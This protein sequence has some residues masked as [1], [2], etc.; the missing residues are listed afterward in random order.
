MWTSTHT[1][2]T[3]CPQ[4][5]TGSINIR[6]TA[7]IPSGLSLS[8]P[9]ASSS[10]S[11]SATAS[12]FAAKRS[13]A[14]VPPPL[15]LASPA[16]YEATTADQQLFTPQSATYPRSYATADWRPAASPHTSS[17][18]VSSTDWQGECDA[19][20]AA[21]AARAYESCPPPRKRA[22]ITP[23][24]SE[25]LPCT[26]PALAATQ[27]HQSAPLSPPP[28]A[29]SSE[30]D[31]SSLGRPLLSATTT[32]GGGRAPLEWPTSLLALMSGDR[33]GPKFRPHVPSNSGSMSQMELDMAG[34]RARDRALVVQWLVQLNATHS[35]FRFTPETMWLAVTYLDRILGSKTARRAIVT[36]L[37]PLYLLAVV[38]LSIAAKFSEEYS[39]PSLATIVDALQSVAATI[40][41]HYPAFQP[42]SA[43]A[44]TEDMVRRMERSA[45]EALH[46]DLTAV[47]PTAAIFEML[48]ASAD[49]TLALVRMVESGGAVGA[50]PVHFASLLPTG[51]VYARP[52]AVV[53]RVV[54]GTACTPLTMPLSP[55]SPPASFSSFDH[56]DLYNHFDADHHDHPEPMLPTTPEMGARPVSPPTTPV[57]ESR[58]SVM[59][60]SSEEEEEGEVVQDDDD[61]DSVSFCND[62]SAASS[63]GA[64]A[65]AAASIRAPVL[66]P[67]AVS[68]DERWPAFLASPE[69]RTAI[70]QLVRHVQVEMV[71]R[72]IMHPQA[73]LFAPMSIGT[74]LLNR[75]VVVLAEAR[76]ME[77]S[78]ASHHHTGFA[79]PPSTPASVRTLAGSGRTVAHGG[80]GAGMT[81]E[82]PC[83]ATNNLDR[84]AFAACVDMVRLATGP[85]S[86]S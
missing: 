25:F 32:M 2:A 13:R 66:L 62:N 81:C 70:A 46:F 27:D 19:A 18:S 52:S 6:R 37:E 53:G 55:K 80:S 22:R 56:H 86:P 1:Q 61:A 73:T 42:H 34:S 65:A 35:A 83:L 23:R 15:S 79:T 77:L 60:Q 10:S 69:H 7:S 74:L 29:R 21:A 72:V 50:A 20:A 39:S 16:L 75:A 85:G 12:S 38:C 63:P 48:F 57:Y 71:Q 26:T 33:S 54:A 31:L 84:Q 11:S 4:P 49:L 14:A 9:Q 28:T 67:P 51:L 5:T 58:L 64:T 45:L 41:Y 3:F 40:A 30:F 24:S 68:K 82:F 76:H 36:S 17:S 47:A 43:L 8:F 44:W 78:S 59:S